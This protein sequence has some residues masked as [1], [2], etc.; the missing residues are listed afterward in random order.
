MADTTSPRIFQCDH[1]KCRKFVAVWDV[2]PPKCPG[3]KRSGLWRTVLQK[4]L[5]AMDRAFLRRH[6][7]KPDDPPTS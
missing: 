2:V 3:C 5:D 1:L 4:E 7:I 6:G